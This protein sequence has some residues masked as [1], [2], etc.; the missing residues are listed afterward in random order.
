MTDEKIVLTKEELH[1]IIKEAVKENMQENSV[2]LTYANLFKDLSRNLEAEVIEINK[3]YGISSYAN[4]NSYD[5]IYP[6]VLGKYIKFEGFKPTMNVSGIP[7]FPVDVH[8]GIRK[9]VLSILGVTRNGDVRKRDYELARKMYS[10]LMRV[11][12]DTY[13][14]RLESAFDE[15]NH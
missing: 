7:Q 5:A 12:I 2:K 8:E 11:S 3:K 13:Q 15:T 9:T 6:A 1:Q 4:R 14:D 10:E